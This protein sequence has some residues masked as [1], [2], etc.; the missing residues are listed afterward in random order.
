MTVPA[1]TYISAA[2]VIAQTFLTGL[3]E[4]NPENITRLIQAAEGQ[5]DKYVGPQPHHPYDD[6][7]D[8]VFPRAQDFSI[9][10][11]G[12]VRREYP[13]TPVIPLDVSMAC[14][15]QVEWLFL[16]WWPNRETAQAP[17]KNYDITDRAI[18]AD[19]SYSESRA[20]AG[21]FEKATLC[22]ET[23]G[24]LANYRSRWA[25]IG[26]TDTR[27]SPPPRYG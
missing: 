19:G 15:K 7:L 4:L 24:Y 25:G 10:Q 11:S 6:N 5:I 14:L 27:T 26:T 21:D 13:E 3:Q 12:G 8:R 9:V 2:D 22:P 16:Q 20:N 1:P 17:V 23:K 18:H